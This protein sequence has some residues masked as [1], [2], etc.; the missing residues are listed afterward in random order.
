MP[1]NRIPSGSSSQNVDQK[2][3]SSSHNSNMHKWLESKTSVFEIY[4][5]LYESDVGCQNIS[6]RVKR[7]SRNKILHNFT[8]DSYTRK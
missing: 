8:E 4:A 1:V 6:D 7:Y 5:I 2:V 3:Q